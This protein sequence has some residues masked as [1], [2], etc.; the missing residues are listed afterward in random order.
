MR[1]CLSDEALVMVIMLCSGK[2][3]LYAECLSLDCC[4]IKSLFFNLSVL[5]P[6]ISWAIIVGLI[7]GNIKR[8]SSCF[9]NWSILCVL[10]VSGSIKSIL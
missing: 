3:G 5:R 9:R 7:L 8:A 1:A 6:N 10:C 4:L 2:L